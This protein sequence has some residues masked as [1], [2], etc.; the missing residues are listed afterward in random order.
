MFICRCPLVEIDWLYP[1]L[2]VCIHLGRVYFKARGVK[3]GSVQ[4]MIK[5][6]LTNISVKSGTVY[7]DVEH[8]FLWSW[9]GPLSSLPRMLMLSCDRIV[10]CVH[11]WERVP[12]GVPCISPLGSWIFPLCTPYYSLFPHTGSFR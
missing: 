7:P 6:E 12:S 3:K 9:L 2:C 10:G 4:D 5:I 8:F 1:L 11:G